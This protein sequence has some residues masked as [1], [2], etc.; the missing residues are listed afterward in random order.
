MPLADDLPPTRPPR[1][2]YGWR[3]SYVPTTTEAREEAC[4]VTEI[5]RFSYLVPAR[6][7]PSLVPATHPHRE[8]DAGAEDEDHHQ[9]RRP[10]AERDRVLAG[11]NNGERTEPEQD[12]PEHPLSVGRNKVE[13][14]APFRQ[15]DRRGSR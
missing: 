3:W 5:F 8:A 1:G 10:E 14:N 11:E 15:Q 7:L 2:D 4:Q 9:N 12:Q 13:S 6:P